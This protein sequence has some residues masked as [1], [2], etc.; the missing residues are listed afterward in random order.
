[1]PFLTERRVTY[2]DG[3]TVVLM[4]VGDRAA[5]S[6]SIQANLR[7]A[8]WTLLQGTVD[9]WENAVK[10]LSSAQADLSRLLTD[11]RARREHRRQARAAK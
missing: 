10:C 1:M 5:V 11:E 7:M 6:A 8:G 9:G 3:Q 4:T 2:P